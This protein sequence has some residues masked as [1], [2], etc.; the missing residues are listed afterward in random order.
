M[1]EA[2]HT[3]TACGAHTQFAEDRMGR[4]VPGHLADMAILSHDLFATSPEE[5]REAVQC[6]MT[7]L[8]GKVVF[9]RHG[10]A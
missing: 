5:L 8:D 3:Y 6:D 1:A 7:I 2:L 10:Q 9:D 4:L